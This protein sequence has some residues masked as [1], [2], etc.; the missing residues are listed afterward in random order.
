M[1]FKGLFKLPA[2]LDREEQLVSSLFTPILVFLLLLCI[3]NFTIDYQNTVGSGGW[4]LRNKIVA[5]RVFAAGK[6]PYTYHLQPGDPLEWFDPI[7]SNFFPVSSFTSP[8][9]FLTIF[10]FIH[11]QSYQAIRISWLYGQWLIFIVSAV[12]LCSTTESLLKRKLILMLFMIYG[13]SLTWRHHVSLGQSY[14]FTVFLMSLVYKILSLRFSQTD[15][16]AGFLQGLFSSL[17]F[18]LLAI[19]LPLLLGRKLHFVA[20]SVVGFLLGIGLSLLIIPI[21]VWQSYFFSM[22]MFSTVQYDLYGTLYAQPTIRGFD[23][24]F[25]QPIDGVQLSIED[26]VLSYIN[27]SLQYQFAE[28]LHIYLNPSLLFILMISV[29]VALSLFLKVNKTQNPL[30]LFAFGTLCYLISELFLPAPRYGYYDMQ[31]LLPLSLI[32]IHHDWKE[33]LTSRLN[34]LL[35]LAA[36]CIIFDLNIGTLFIYLYAILMYREIFLTNELA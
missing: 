29:L 21:S 14:I 34:I 36:G 20:G 7:D 26:P 18:P 3:F 33:L 35:G 17:R 28:H 6:D 8:P 22:K 15:M 4:D 1:N 16:V 19:N 25:A 27:T 31:W 2:I 10:L 23:E 30:R 12:L 24:P 32:I 13:C 9:T 5:A 11:E